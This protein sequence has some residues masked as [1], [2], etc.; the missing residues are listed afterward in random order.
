MRRS[1]TLVSVAI[2]AFS[3]V[4]VASALYGYRVS[5]RARSEQTLASQPEVRQASTEMIAAAA[6]LTTSV[7]PKQAAALAAEFLGRTDLYSVQLV[8]YSGVQAYKVTFSSGDVVYISLS[9]QVLGSEIAPVLIAN[10]NRNERETEDSAGEHEG[11]EE[12]EAEDHGAE[13]G[14]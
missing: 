4:M 10:V 11:G 13:A 12:H 9:G 5:A 3:S 8:E 2:T 1:I 7:M 6:E 14:D